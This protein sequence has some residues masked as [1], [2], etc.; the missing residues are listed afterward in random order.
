MTLILLLTPV[1]LKLYQC[2]AGIFMVTVCFV[3]FTRINRKY[4]VI[5]RSDIV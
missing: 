4:F 1:R 3:I 5:L 2:R